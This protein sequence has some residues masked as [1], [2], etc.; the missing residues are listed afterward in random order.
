V[1]AKSCTR[2][3]KRRI[4][5]FSFS[6]N[7]AL[8]PHFDIPVHLSSVP[9]RRYIITPVSEVELQPGFDIPALQKLDVPRVLVDSR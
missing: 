4:L 6:P 1:A 7:V 8:Q 3:S 9:T 2:H 5:L